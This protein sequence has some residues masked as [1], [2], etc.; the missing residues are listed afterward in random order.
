MKCLQ[1]IRTKRYRNV[2]LL[3]LFCT[4]VFQVNA[5]KAQSPNTYSISYGPNYNTRDRKA[6]VP[7]GW[8]T[9]ASFLYRPVCEL[10]LGID[11]DVVSTSHG[12]TGWDSGVGNLGFEAHFT[13]KFLGGGLNTKNG[14]CIAVDHPALTFDYV[15][16]VPVPSTVESTELAHLVKATFNKPLSNGNVFVTA[17]ANVAGVTTGGYA[18]NAVLSANYQRNLTKNALWAG[19]L[20]TDL[21]SASANGPSSAIFLIAFDR[22]SKNQAWLARFGSSFGVTPYAPKASPFLTVIYN[23]KFPTKK[24]H[25]A[26]ILRY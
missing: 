21:A 3:L 6:T 24:T 10:A 9:P 23:G 13:P 12:A 26:S 15:V 19:E 5:A 18:T 14:S 2:L 11:D 20:E 8:V 25:H 4:A 7:V 16:T 22:S 1:A 17:G